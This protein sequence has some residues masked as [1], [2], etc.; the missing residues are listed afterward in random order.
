[1]SHLANEWACGVSFTDP[2]P[3]F[4]NCTH[5]ASASDGGDVIRR[6][7]IGNQER[8]GAFCSGG[9]PGRGIGR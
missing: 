5:G 6:P 7:I 1:M 8:A 4:Q 2:L 3:M 9:S